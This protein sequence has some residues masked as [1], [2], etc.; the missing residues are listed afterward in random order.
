MK[1]LFFLLLVITFNKVCY[2]QKFAPVGA[3]WHYSASGNGTAPTRSEYYLYESQMDTTIWGQTMQKISITYYTYHRNTIY[4][5]PMYVFQIKDTVYYYNDIYNSFFPLYIFN[6]AK[7]DTLT[8]H[9]PVIPSDP[10]NI[11]WKVVVDS[12]TSFIV[13][14]DTLQKVWNRSLGPW[15]YGGS[16]IELIGSPNLFLPQYIYAIPEHDGPLRCYTDNKISYNFSSLP[17]EYRET[18]GIEE[19]IKPYSFM[20][21]PNPATNEINIQPN[22]N[23]PYTYQIFNTAGQILMK[24]TSASGLSTLFI[25]FLSEGIYNIEISAGDKIQRKRFIVKK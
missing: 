8:F 2:S 20:V 7:G 11:T 13:G 14:S 5:P 17:C 23:M 19:S 1:Q 24:G 18:D 15:T 22:L 25:N 4:L 10:K 9:A 6:V 21:Y 16:Y 12:T 3:K